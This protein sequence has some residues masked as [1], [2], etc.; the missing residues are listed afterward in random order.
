MSYH[1]R[2][3]SQVIGCALGSLFTVLIAGLLLAGVYHYS[4]P[5]APP[6]P[7]DSATPQAPAAIEELSAADVLRLSE[8]R[9]L[10]AASSQSVWPGWQ[11]VPPLL[12]HAGEHDY[13]IG[14]PAP[15]SNFTRLPNAQL[16]GQPVYRASGR[17]VP[18]PAATA[19]LVGD[20]WSIAVPTLID[21]QRAID[22]QLGP[23]VVT[24]D[25]A[26]YVRTLSHEAFHTYQLTQVGGPDRL[27]T[28][29]ATLDEA[30]A[31]KR[32]GAPAELDRYAAEG[33]T[34]LD[35]LTA[36]TNDEAKQA[37]AHFGQL[38]QQR[39]AAMP[40]IAGIER[41]LE[42]VEGLARYA[43][44]R[45]MQHAGANAT[46]SSPI[47]Y[48]PPDRVWQ[49]F[50]AQLANPAAIS[51]GPRD[52]Y[53]A[54]GAAQA[55]LLDRLLPDWKTRALPGNIALEELLSEAARP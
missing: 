9:R 45:L 36:A 34:L 14:H 55:W 17:Q 20:T 18:V 41:T 19:W 48:Q 21:F 49:D 5:A 53:A 12:I 10:L 35:A 43:E 25:E 7:A 27:P 31:L 2:P 44:I 47:T 33:Q 51:T 22:A 37:A 16:D 46:S 38:R 15:P 3:Q 40:D 23:G 11:T 39:R 50:T 32:L 6:A 29:G 26:S 28:F 30:E 54:F 1:D 13:L 52:R 8:V 4:R 42:W 24:L